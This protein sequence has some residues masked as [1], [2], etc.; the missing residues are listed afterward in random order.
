MRKTLNMDK[1][2]KDARKRYRLEFKL[3]K[4]RRAQA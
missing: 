2:D 3:W 1:S 4:R